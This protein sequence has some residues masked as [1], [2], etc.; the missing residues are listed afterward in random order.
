MKSLL[1]DTQA[2]IWALADP[3]R[4][5]SAR[6]TIESPDSTVYVSA[7]SL[8]EMEIKRAMGKLDTPDDLEHQLRL[9]RFTELPLRA[10]HVVPLRTL[11]PLHRDPFDRMLVAQCLADDLTLVTHDEQVL[12]YPVKQLRIR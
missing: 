4:L 3:Q 7:V 12:A 5:Y 1:L 10:R 8:W 6:A 11:P 9:R 2:L